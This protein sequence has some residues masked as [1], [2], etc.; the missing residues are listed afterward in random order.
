[1]K[2]IGA[3]MVIYY[4]L[5]G[6][7]QVSSEQLS[8]MHKRLVDEIGEVLVDT[9]LRSIQNAVATL[10]AVY[11]LEQRDDG[12]LVGKK[13]GATSLFLNEDFLD[14]C[15]A[16]FFSEEEFAKIKRIFATS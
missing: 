2:Y 7:S 3:D 8:R 14:R 15:F 9:T 16:P 4:A 1:M 11:E 10:P 6:R 12:F 13:A 5:L